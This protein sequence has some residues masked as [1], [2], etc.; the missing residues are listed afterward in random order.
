MTATWHQDGIDLLLKMTA[1][2][3]TISNYGVNINMYYTDADFSYPD[4]LDD[5]SSRSGNTVTIQRTP[6]CATDGTVTS[7][8]GVVGERYGGYTTTEYFIEK[9]GIDDAIT[10]SETA[11]PKISIEFTR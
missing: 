11:N 9:T 6:L 5:W 2:L 1:G 8:R 4:Y 10:T 7:I 3:E